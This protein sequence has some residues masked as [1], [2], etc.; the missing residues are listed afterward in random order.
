MV[1]HHRP[2]TQAAEIRDPRQ[3]QRV[4]LG[5][6]N[7]AE[8]VGH[9]LLTAQH[10]Y[11]M[12]PYQLPSSFHNVRRRTVLRETRMQSEEPVAKTGHWC[13][14]DLIVNIVCILKCLLEVVK[15]FL[16]TS[17]SQLHEVA[18]NAHS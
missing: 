17:C 14:T 8:E 1:A 6:F 3:G 9:H 11:D 12:Q 16:H 10:S 18:V 2:V 4:W 7:S 15:G 5:T 13:N